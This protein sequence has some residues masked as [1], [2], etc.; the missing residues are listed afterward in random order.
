MWYMDQEYHAK[1]EQAEPERRGGSA[2]EAAEAVQ[3]ELF[4]LL[5]RLPDPDI[6]SDAQKDRERKRLRERLKALNAVPRSD[7]HREFENIMQIEIESW[8]NDA[9]I[10]REVSIGEDAPRVD[11]MM[12]SGTALSEDVKSVFR[13]FRSKNAVEYKR[14]SEA[15]TEQMVWKTGGYAALLIGTARGSEYDR[16]A[17]TV[18]IFA[19]TKNRTQ[20]ASMMERGLI[21]ATETAGIYRVNGMVPLPYQIVIIE[22]LEGREYAAYR[23]LS[24]HTDIEDLSVILDAMRVCPVSIKDRYFSILQTIEVHNPG[25]VRELIQEERQMNT[26]FFEMFKPEL[27]KLYEPEF[28]EREK[29]AAKAATDSAVK[30]TYH[31]VAERL[32]RRGMDGPGMSLFPFTWKAGLPD[33][34][35]SLE[36]DHKNCN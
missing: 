31:T 17:L 7:W 2:K 30:S 23:A 27:L 14:P 34:S 18:S 28:Q 21:E 29:A 19:Y 16:D 32:I 13:I 1:A 11:F 33:I 20:F 4:A 9:W 5:P 25:A 6:L 36:K 15:L 12:V 10:E 22:E 24:E 26:S 35:F 8:H 3:N